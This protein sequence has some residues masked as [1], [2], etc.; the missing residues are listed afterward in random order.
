VEV[1]GDDDHAADKTINRYARKGLS[2]PLARRQV[3]QEQREYTL[4]QIDQV[5][6]SLND[7]THQFTSGGGQHAANRAA[8]SEFSPD[9]ADLLPNAA[10]A[11]GAAANAA[12]TK[13]TM[14]AMRYFA[15]PYHGIK[16]LM[17]MVDEVTDEFNR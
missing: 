1:E 12:L 3:R 17:D 4:S 11:A 10:M 7:N 2:E 14:N 15:R 9:G 8:Q 5:L 6:D 13:D 16:S